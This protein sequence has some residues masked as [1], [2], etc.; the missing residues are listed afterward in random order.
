MKP[1]PEHAQLRKQIADD[2]T[3]MRAGDLN[4]QERLDALR[5]GYKLI[6]G[7]NRSAFC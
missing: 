1:V 4:S 5:G 6:G 3:R 7:Q 2:L